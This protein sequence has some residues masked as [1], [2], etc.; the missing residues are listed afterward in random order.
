MRQRLHV[1]LWRT[2]TDALVVGI[3][4]LYLV[5]VGR[6]MATIR[7]DLWGAFVAVPVIAAIAVPLV[8]WFFRDDL[9]HLRRIAVIGLGVKL[10]GTIT[11]Y[12]VVND[13]YGGFADS[14]G[15]HAL[16][17][18]YAGGF[19]NGTVTFIGLTPHTRGT[20][21]IGE[22]TGFIYSFAGSSKL[23]G[24]LWFGLLGYLGV[25][26]CVKAA[27]IAV[28]GLRQRQYA[29]LCYLL[30]SLVFWP[31][32][33]GKEAW[34]SLTL[35]AV[36]MGVARFTT[37]RR[38]LGTWAWLVLGLL[39]AN[40]VRPHFAGIWLAAFALSTTWWL[41]AGRQDH[42]RVSQRQN[43]LVAVALVIVAVLGIVAMAKATTQYLLPSAEGSSTSV[44][45]LL[46]LT[47]ER[48]STGGSRFEQVSIASPLDYPWAV[49][50][51]LTRPFI[52][53][54]NNIPTTLV[55]LE[56]TFVLVLLG[57]RLR[58]LS[59]LRR[60]ANRNAYVLYC[61]LVCILGS[62]AMATFGNLAILVR[63]RSLL[64]PFL[65]L[66]PCLPL[67]S[68]GSSRPQDA[69]DRWA[70]LYHFRERSLR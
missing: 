53:E 36:S 41:A 60:W 9:A 2:P 69:A 38:S 64:M 13:A 63:Q 33:I 67:I 26:F 22:L 55:A 40:M 14:N 27:A 1:S 61:I 45:D 15:Y 4:M 10:A 19:W 8:R 44:N 24:F 46:V 49:V 16:G 21:F 12:W 34:M 65:M 57:A 5:V 17:R 6:L 7:Y 30:P 43:P 52:W 51:T 54:V 42:Q 68:F 11:R 50:R 37:G 39:G 18:T 47:S 58:H 20:A 23:A 48:T 56:A 62:L 32:S 28:P 35:G 59:S 70:G 29:W 31:S 3:G 25:C 66:L